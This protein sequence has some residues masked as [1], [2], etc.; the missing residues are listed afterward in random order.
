[1]AGI[2]E[3]YEPEE[4]VGRSIVVVANLKPATSLRKYEILNH[5]GELLARAETDWAFINYER[6]R[7]VRIPAEVAERFIVVADAATEEKP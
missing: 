7:A 6:Q 5:R 3:S 4:L 2:A 1:M